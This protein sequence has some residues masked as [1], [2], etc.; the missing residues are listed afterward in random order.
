MT[1]PTVQKTW[2]FSASNRI[3]YVSLNDTAASYMFGVKAFLKTAGY[4]VKGS[5]D[6]T[7]GAMD[8]VD[9]WAT[10]A[11]ATTRGAAAGN[12]QSWVVL[13][14]GSGVDILIA[15]MGSVDDRFLVSFSPS[16]VFA[17]AGTPNQQPTATDQQNFI[18]GTATMVGTATSGDRVWHAMVDSQNKMFRV[19]IASAGSFVGLTWGV[20]IIS[21]RVTGGVSFTPPVWG[22]SWLP[23]QLTAAAGTGFGSTYAVNSR[24]GLAKANGIN[25]NCEGGLEYFGGAP[26][27]WGNVK[28]ELQGATGYPIFPLSIGSET[29]GAQGPLGDLFDWWLGRTSSVSHG[30][31]YGSN[32]FVCVGPGV[33]WPW[34]GVSPPTM[35]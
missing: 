19:M 17:A 15:Y 32:Q 5:C 6:G 25:L 27:N 8:A 26:N 33:F 14:D 11:N 1:L 12:A 21:S 9:R 30:D 3:T 16:G 34:T 28:T 4:T 7:T 23:T 22:F 24:G 20:E 18:P 10:K 29:A 2:A 13:T 35:A 31:V